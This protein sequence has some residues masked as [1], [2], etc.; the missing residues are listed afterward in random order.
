MT[1]AKQNGKARNTPNR[2]GRSKSEIAA[3]RETIVFF[4]AFTGGNHLDA[5]SNSRPVDTV[6]PVP[7]H[8]IEGDFSPL[9]VWKSRLLKEFF[10]LLTID[11]TNR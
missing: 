6:P 5:K 2:P 4:Q 3:V 7:S 10:F 11:V 9:L 8:M 1:G